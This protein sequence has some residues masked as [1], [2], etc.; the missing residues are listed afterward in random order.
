MWT[1]L[2]AAISQDSAVV[3]KVLT[4]TGENLSP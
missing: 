3:L 4:S 1:F 2:A